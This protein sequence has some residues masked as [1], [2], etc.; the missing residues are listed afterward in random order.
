MNPVLLIT[1]EVR[2]S[3]SLLI[4]E[5]RGNRRKGITTREDDW[6][7][8]EVLLGILSLNWDLGLHGDNDDFGG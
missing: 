3:N 5:I 1:K 6:Q 2:L 8:S 7:H 4:G